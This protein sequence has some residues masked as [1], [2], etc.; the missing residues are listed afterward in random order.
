MTIIARSTLLDNNNDLSLLLSL[1]IKDNDITI[2]SKISLDYWNKYWA[3]AK[4]AI[5]LSIS[6]IYF[7]YYKVQ[8]K[9]TNLLSCYCVLVNLAIINRTPLKR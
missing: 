8:T 9:D 3:K 5:S 1:F 4:E 7:R 6:K 2:L